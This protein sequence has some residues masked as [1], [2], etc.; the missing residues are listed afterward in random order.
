MKEMLVFWLSISLNVRFWFLF[1]SLEWI[2]Y[3][4]YLKLNMSSLRPLE[5]A[6]RRCLASLSQTSPFTTVFSGASALT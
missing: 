3:C 2:Y 1:V 4:D 5:Y 6:E